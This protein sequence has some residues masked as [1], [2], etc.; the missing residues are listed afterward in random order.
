MIVHIIFIVIYISSIYFSHYTIVNE[1]IRS[2]YCGSFLQH[3]YRV[4]FSL[5]NQICCIKMMLC[6]FH[7]R[8]ARVWVIQYVRFM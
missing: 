7:N 6:N 1:T 2:E 8:G 4:I 5:L 3:G